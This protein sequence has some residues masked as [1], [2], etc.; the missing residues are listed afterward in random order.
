MDEKWG[1]LVAEQT[2]DRSAAVMAERTAGRWVV[3][4]VAR[5]VVVL[6][7]QTVVC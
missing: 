6:A 1:A 4:M 3:W 5:R 2:V 7:F